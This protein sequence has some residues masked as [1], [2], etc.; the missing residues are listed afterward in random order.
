MGLSRGVLC[1]GCIMYMRCELFIQHLSVCLRER[2]GRNLT[3]TKTEDD[4]DDK[5]D[6]DD[7]DNNDNDNIIGP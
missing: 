2:N 1:T 4:D 3:K 5:D 6:K 7:N